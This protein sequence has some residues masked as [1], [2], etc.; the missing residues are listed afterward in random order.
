M[1]RAAGF[2]RAA[3]APSRLSWDAFPAVEPGAA[4]PEDAADAAGRVDA[5]TEIDTAEIRD[6]RIDIPQADL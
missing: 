1:G 3:G 6:F 5:M 4:A 2:W